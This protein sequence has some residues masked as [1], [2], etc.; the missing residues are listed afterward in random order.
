MKKQSGFQR[1]RCRKFMLPR[2]VNNRPKV[3]HQRR[4]AKEIQLIYAHFAPPVIFSV[5]ED[6]G[7][8]LKPGNKF[9]KTSLS[10]RKDAPGTHFL[11]EQKPGVG[12]TPPADVRKRIQF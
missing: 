1:L 9:I 10:S 8:A 6:L 4:R 11:T 7:Y 5:T 2:R 3:H 12:Q